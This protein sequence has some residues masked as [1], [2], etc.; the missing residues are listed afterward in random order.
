LAVGYY[1]IFL[2]EIG[3]EVVC[4]V[5]VAWRLL[6][7][8]LSLLFLFL[9]AMAKLFGMRV[10]EIVSFVRGIILLGRNPRMSVFARYSRFDYSVV[11]L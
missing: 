8:C 1:V 7:P 2:P 11:N 10:D 3:I 6:F 9:S 4:R 5:C